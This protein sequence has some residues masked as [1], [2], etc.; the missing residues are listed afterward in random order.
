MARAFILLTHFVDTILKHINHD[1]FCTFWYLLIPFSTFFC[2]FCPM[3]LLLFCFFDTILKHVNQKSS[4][5]SNG[6]VFDSFCVCW[7]T[8]Q[9][10]PFWLISYLWDLASRINLGCFTHICYAM[11]NF[12]VEPRPLSVRESC[13]N[14]WKCCNCL[15]W[16]IL[17]FCHPFSQWQ[18]SGNKGDR[19]N[20]KHIYFLTDNK[21]SPSSILYS[22]NS[23]HF[24]SI[25]SPQV[26]RKQKEWAQELLNAH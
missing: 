10:L 5:S 14:I 23:G 9:F 7:R 2:I 17:N 24:T 16:N 13:L 19:T 25:N 4:A 8:S 20:W 3:V 12:F 22:K 11:L 1:S 18:F 26:W 15:K 6:K 21:A